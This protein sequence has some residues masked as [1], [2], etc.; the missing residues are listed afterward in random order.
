MLSLGTRPDNRLPPAMKMVLDRPT[1]GSMAG[2]A[3]G[4]LQRLQATV[5]PAP[6]S[7]ERTGAE[8]NVAG[9]AETQRL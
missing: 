3:L 9:R 8:P 7:P 1:A 2:P 4:Q 6:S 5:T